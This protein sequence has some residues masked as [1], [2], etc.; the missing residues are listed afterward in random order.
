MA[1]SGG[2]GVYQ[3][4][5]WW[6]GGGGCLKGSK[7]GW[8]NPCAAPYHVI[9]CDHGTPSYCIWPYQAKLL[10]GQTN[11]LYILV[12]RSFF[13]QSLNKLSWNNYSQIFDNMWAMKTFNENLSLFGHD[14]RWIPA[15]CACFQ[16]SGKVLSI[17]NNIKG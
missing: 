10:F 6:Q 8:R 12:M 3:K 13:M 9:V 16:M 15:M 17:C 2:V 4:M 7:K 14:N 1:S 5:A 11:C